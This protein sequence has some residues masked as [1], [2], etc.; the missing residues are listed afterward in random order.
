VLAA[1]IIALMMEAATTSETVVN[2]YQTTRRYNPE[3]SHLRTISVHEIRPLDPIL[4]Q[5]SPYYI[6]APCFVKDEFFSI[7]IP[8]TLLLPNV[9]FL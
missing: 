4:V 8:Y 9:S 6:I 7:L 1:S 3:D 5:F 2:F